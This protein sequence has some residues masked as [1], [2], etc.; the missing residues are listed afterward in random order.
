MYMTNILLTGLSDWWPY[1]TSAAGLL[2]TLLALWPKIKNSVVGKLTS[3]NLRLRAL[4][5]D[6]TLE[7]EIKN[8]ILLANKN[9]IGDLSGQIDQLKLELVDIHRKQ[10]ERIH[11]TQS[12]ENPDRR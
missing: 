10:F 7:A 5:A 2:A 4:V 11:D 6:M 1:I 3:E 8:V 12:P 9:E